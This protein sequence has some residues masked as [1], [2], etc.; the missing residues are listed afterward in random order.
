M[1]YFL[2]AGGL[3]G[4]G[5]GYDFPAFDG[6]EFRERCA[7]AGVDVDSIFERILGLVDDCDGPNWIGPDECRRPAEAQAFNDGA[8]IGP[9]P[10]LR[11]VFAAGASD[12][13]GVEII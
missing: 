1:A 10:T 4:D 2:R 13:R 12:P 9:S 5:P 6:P 8:W 3:D 11:E 7:R